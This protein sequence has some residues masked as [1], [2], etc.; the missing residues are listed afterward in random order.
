MLLD[1]TVSDTKFC[2][3]I[4]T[5]VYTSKF[6]PHLYYIHLY[7]FLFSVHCRWN[8]YSWRRNVEKIPLSGW[9]ECWIRFH[10]W[11]G[12]EMCLRREVLYKY[13]KNI[14]EPWQKGIILDIGAVGVIFFFF[15]NWQN[16]KCRVVINKKLFSAIFSH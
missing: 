16:S 15:F 8:L 1:Y 6:H 14:S 3:C 2:R 9:T 10:W 12:I 13:S 5:S 11:V 4:L 7:Y